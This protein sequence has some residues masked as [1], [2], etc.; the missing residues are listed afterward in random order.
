[1]SCSSMIWY[2]L[3]RSDSRVL[4]FRESMQL[5]LLYSG[6]PYSQESL[7]DTHSLECLCFE[8]RLDDGTGK[9]ETPSMH[10]R[11][12]L[13]LRVPKKNGQ[14]F[15]ISSKPSKFGV[16]RGKASQKKRRDVPPKN[17]KPWN[18]CYPK[19]PLTKPTFLIFRFSFFF[20]F[21]FSS[22]PSVCS[23]FF[24][25]SALRF[26]VFPVF[27]STPGENWDGW[28]CHGWVWAPTMEG[29]SK[30]LQ[31]ARKIRHV[32]IIQTQCLQNGGFYEII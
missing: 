13:L 26:A 32:C 27:C 19:P 4:P 11:L 18:P 14:G 17:D 20:P 7:H 1:M 5:E 6:E 12:I 31:Q 2:S 10:K 15:A 8:V 24:G 3:W 23:A 21:F 29:R 22:W 30:E 9:E 28:L 25:F 16:R